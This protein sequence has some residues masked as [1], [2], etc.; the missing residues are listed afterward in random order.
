M[1]QSPG[2]VYRFGPFRYDTAQRL[3]FREGELVPLVPKAIDTLHVLLERRGEVVGKAE[4]MKAVWPDCV[5]EE[6]GLARNVSLL[7]KALG[8][9]AEAYIETIPKRGYRF[10]AE[11]GET[12]SMRA[13][14][15]QVDVPVLPQCA[16]RPR[17]T[18][19]VLS[20]VLLGLGGVVYWQFYW[21]SRYL[22][23]VG[24]SAS[25]AVVPFECLSP[26][27]ER[28]AF[29]EGFTEALVEEIAKLKSVQV[30]SPSTVQRYR[31]LR[32]P[33]AV[34][35]RL[36]GLHVVVEGTAQSFGPQLRISVR[37]TDVHSGKLIWAD[38]YDVAAAD[39]NQTETAVARGVAAQIGR[40][41]S[42][43]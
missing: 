6:V 31:R 36:L 26:D 17:R 18:W 30:I 40:R 13:L 34:M 4:L 12:A 25:L 37:L 29:S 5:V 38:G 19:L 8:E 20:V 35:A 14:A 23:R 27:L 2:T 1:S 42:P 21:P 43:R 28:A 16:G 7:R 33:T 3:L 39:M 9:D 10:T 41:L 32:I 11:V 22:P 24:G 15:A